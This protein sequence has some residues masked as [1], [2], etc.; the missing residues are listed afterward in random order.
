MGGSSTPPLAGR[1][2][3]QPEILRHMLDDLD[4]GF[5]DTPTTVAFYDELPLW[6]APFGLL[7]LE[8][9]PLRAGASVLD[10]G[11]GTGFPLLELAE[12]LGASAR[13]VGLDPWRNALDR[14]RGKIAAYRI[15]NVELV[16][17]S[18]ERMPFAGATFDLVTSNLGINNVE[19]LPRSL[20]ECRRVL[21]P[22]GRLALTTNLYGHWREFYDQFRE[23]LR[24]VGRGELCAALEAHERHRATVA[25][26]T[27]DLEV[28][29][30]MVERVEEREFAMRFVDGGS[31]LR[32]HFIRLGFVEAWKKV[33]PE[34]DRVL[35][36]GRLEEDL[37]R[38]AADLGELRLT[39]PMAYL[40]AVTA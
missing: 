9:A 40:Q 2:R 20:A 39:V 13:L 33:V 7:L 36:F 11:C 23:T 29:G 1:S 28:A 25:S 27:A 15:G 14:L 26:I 18:A 17:G 19:D 24:S 35:I 4:S 21:R 37:N 30:F 22:E 16:E 32:H 8:Y 12:R 38:L 31:F 3:V 5:Q 34:V 10:I 6:S